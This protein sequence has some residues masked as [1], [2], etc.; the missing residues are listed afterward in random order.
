MEYILQGDCSGGGCCVPIAM[1]NALVWWGR[2]HPRPGTPEWELLV[3]VAL[4]RHGSAIRV[5]EVADFLGLIV[6]RER[7]EDLLRPDGPLPLSVS[8]HDPK[9]G[10][11]RILVTQRFHGTNRLKVVNYC[12]KDAHWVQFDD[13]EIV[14]G[15]KLAK[16]HPV[17]WLVP[18]LSPGLDSVPRNPA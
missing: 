11:H 18:R 4:C 1:V 17:E 2:P 10:F 6:M 9:Y 8:V 14:D 7:E 5:D 15:A 3:D 16:G 13:L 12:G